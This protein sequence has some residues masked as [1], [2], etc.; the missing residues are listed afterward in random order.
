MIDESRITY[1]NNRLVNTQGEYILY[2][3]HQTPRI[4]GNFALS[5][6]IEQSHQLKKPLLV[7]FGISDTYPEANLRHFYFLIQG[8]QEFYRS[9]KEM[10][11]RMII[12]H[13][14]ADKGAQ[15]LSKKAALVVSDF[16]YLRHTRKW[17]SSVASSVEVPFVE[18]ESNVVVP[19][20]ISSNKEE[21]S[22]ATLRR[23]IEPLI[24]YFGTMGHE[25]EY[26]GVFCDQTFLIEDIY[27]QDTDVM[28][29]SLQI[30]RSVPPS[31]FIRGGESASREALTYFIEN[32]L[33]GY[34]AHHNDPLLDYSSNLSAY[35]HF[36]HIS[37][38][39]VYQKV[40]QS[41]CEDRR[42][43]I[44]Q[45]IVRR[46]LAFNF[47]YYNWQYDQFEALP[48]WAKE[49]LLEYSGD[50]R[51]YTYTFDQLDK[52]LTHDRYW[53]AAQKE[54]RECGTMHNYMRMYWGK[55]I[56]Q[57]NDNPQVAY[58]YALRLNNTY[59]LDGRD[60]NGFAGVAWCFG[61]HD[62]PWARRSI[63]GSVRYMNDKGLERKFEMKKY[64]D[65]VDTLIGL[66]R[67]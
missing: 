12:G 4:V 47:V 57:W 20:R 58:R 65:H 44:E 15:L 59:Q 17:N 42:D 2:W 48:R 25:L 38:I 54:L 10:N 9:L 23:K 11:I 37:P 36:G 26:R 1:L 14:S 39:E 45:L 56:L 33:D 22:A 41:D 30:D 31:F 53:N 50:P 7:Y 32:R 55:K 61:K 18:V 46:E 51:E 62:R 52:G 16:A 60:P 27:H 28:V 49:T 66:R 8:V 29:N 43:F 35:L 24:S 13:I 19:V 67:P 40:L 5:F 63:F 21:Y 34:S 64:V 6:A 3:V